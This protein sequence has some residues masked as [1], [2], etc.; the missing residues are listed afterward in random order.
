VIIESDEEEEEE[1]ERKDSG[2]GGFY[3]LS[4]RYP[5][6]SPVNGRLRTMG[7]EYKVMNDK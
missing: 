2:S 4:P 1:E 3:R 5:K 7:S 6:L